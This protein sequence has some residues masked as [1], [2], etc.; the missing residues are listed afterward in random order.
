MAG[1]K[2]VTM[3]LGALALDVE[4]QPRET[5]DLDLVGEYAEA[6]AAGAVFL[7]GRVPQ[8][9][10]RAAAR[11]WLAPLLRPRARRPQRDRSRGA[12][13]DRLDALRYSLAP[14]PGTAG[15]ATKAP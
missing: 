5:I 3:A 11:R 6:I 13:G 2:V 10:G 14:M 4:L 9:H 12:R 8:R 7:L 1:T 15:A